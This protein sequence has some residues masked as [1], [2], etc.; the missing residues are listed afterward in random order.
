MGTLRWALRTARRDA[1]G[2]RA[3]AVLYASSMALG[4]AALVAMGSLGADLGEAVDGQTRELLGADL[5]VW[6]RQPF[7]APVTD[8][9]DEI[10][11]EQS[12]I[13]GF[14]SMAYFPAKDE[15]QLARVRGIEGGFPFYGE[16]E[17]TPPEAVTSFRDGP[18][19]LVSR[20]LVE[21]MEARIGDVVR[22]GERDF[23]LAG[24]V[25]K[26]PGET[27]MTS[28]MGPRIYL[29]RRYLDETGLLRQGSRI[30]HWRAFSVPA[31]T[32]L[33][34]LVTAK[35]ELFREHRLGWDTVKTR[36]ASMGEG[37][38]HLQG[39][40]DLVACLTLL[41]GGIG[42][43]GA[44]HYHIAQKKTQI[45]VMRCLGATVGQVMTVYL[46][47][48]AAMALIA[49]VLGT[50]LGVALQFYLP[51]LI[52]ELIP[53]EFTSSLQ[54]VAILIAASWGL[55]MSLLLA[56]APL[57]AIRRM[58]PLLSFRPDAIEATRDKAA[59]LAYAGVALVWWIFATVQTE[60]LMRGSIFIGSLLTALI[61]LWLT[62]RGL[63]WL[64]RRV[65]SPALPFSPRYAVAHL[66]RPN[67]QTSVFLII[68]GM[69][70]FLVTILAGTRT[71][72]LDPFTQTSKGDRPNFIAFDIQVDQV[73]GVRELISDQGLEPSP[74][75]PMVPMRL[76]SLAGRDIAE[77]LEEGEVP[78]WALRREYRSTYR[79]H[80]TGTE[81]LIEG[82]FVAR[83]D[84]DT[85]PIPV[86]FERDILESLQ[87][88]LGDSVTV[89]ILGI[90]LELEVASVRQVDWQSMQ[91][92]FYMVFPKGVLED[93]PGMYVLTARTSDPSQVATLQTELVKAYPNISCVDMT[94][95]V[96]SID[97]ITDKVMTVIQFLAGLCIFTGFILL[98]SAIWN[99]RYERR[100]EHALLRTL[101]ADRGKMARITL[102][103][104]F[105][106]GLFASLTGLILAFAATWGLGIFLFEL[107]PFPNPLA[108]LPP[109]L[110]L[111]FI[112]LTLGYLSLRGVWQ[113]SPR[114]V[115]RGEGA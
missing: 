43:A 27:A 91:P 102:I 66:F 89:D 25:D 70:I 104:Y 5:M 92:N 50:L 7:E 6:S 60:S 101:G 111:P 95:M 4:I 45:A 59:W 15:A 75:T 28:L 81:E 38:V 16:I 46:I 79:D 23:T 86:S 47:Q 13:T 19:A 105:L 9:F 56:A 106:L 63:G 62:A 67:N 54:P 64:A 53:F 82:A 18:N 12:A 76:A 71:M 42:V 36:K 113:V 108:L 115:L 52:R 39:F 61:V 65:L 35:E 73:E 41:L 48:V 99:A 80:L 68:L 109:A 96:E 90:P 103:E 34:A 57:L 2:A 93:A 33:D 17:T 112:T 58:S 97:E 40:L 20:T 30:F 100:G 98:G 24:I 94:A 22:I 51:V 8:F 77:L 21:R 44:V 31:G 107:P 85:S 88:G 26:V 110:I 3:K 114:L 14:A 83:V 72:L 69:G 29:P 78:D 55:V 84:P 49:I 32:E 87:L 37:M 1:R 10:P 74:A 11:G